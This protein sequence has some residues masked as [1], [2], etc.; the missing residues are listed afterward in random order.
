MFTT[1]LF[2]TVM[3]I[4]PYTVTAK[5]NRNR[6]QCFSFMFLMNYWVRRVMKIYLLHIYLLTTMCKTEPDTAGAGMMA[7]SE[8][9]TERTAEGTCSVLATPSHGCMDIILGKSVIRWKNSIGHSTGLSF[10]AWFIRN[11]YL[12]RPLEQPLH[13][14]ESCAL[15]SRS[16]S[17]WLVTVATYL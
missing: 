5:N 11:P 14:M 1:L 4:M 13:R 6:R 10:P 9:L 17:A 12:C 16:P 8:P 7:E 3:F 2:T 15:F